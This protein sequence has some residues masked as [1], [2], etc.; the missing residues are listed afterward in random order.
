MDMNPA[1]K[2]RSDIRHSSS[3]LTPVIG[4]EKVEPGAA[5]LLGG[6]FSNRFDRTLLCP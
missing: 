2:S 6:M 1:Q 5:D 4:K 3:L